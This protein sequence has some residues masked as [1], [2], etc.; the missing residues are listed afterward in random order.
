VGLAPR[1]AG[2]LR[3]LPASRLLDVQARVTPR[4]GGVAC[5]PVAD[6]TEL[7]ADPEAAI[8]AG[9]A[10]GVPLLV[11]SNS[12]EQRFFHRLDPEAAHLTDEDLLARLADPRTTARAGDGARFDPTA[13]VAG[14]RR[15]RAARGE[16]TTAPELWVAVMSDRRYGV[17]A[18]RLAALQAAHTPHTYAYLFT[19]GAPAG[20]GRPG[21]G[22]AAEVPFVFGTLDAPGVRDAV[23]A[24]A[25]P[26]GDLPAHMQ[27]AW[28]AFAR[29]G[30]PRTPALPGWE[31]YAAP[32]RCTMLLGTPSAPADAPYEAERRFW[33][34][35]TSAE[36]PGPP[37]GG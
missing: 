16:G 35:A 19:W 29:T 24:G 3:D 28:L 33:E 18:M 14:Y 26:V 27:D 21:A 22:H 15:A 4:A 8:A 10:A 32:R 31:P 36:A 2:R 23:P 20:G 34:T 1:E 6:G 5:G 13:A 30:S 37:P 17:P 25:P 7:P 11:G 9:S 12:E